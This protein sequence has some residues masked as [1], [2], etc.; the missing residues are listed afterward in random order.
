M[1]KHISASQIATWSRC[2]YLWQ[3]GRLTSGTRGPEG[4]PDDTWAQR[5]GHFVHAVEAMFKSCSV[6]QRTEG[7]WIAIP[8]YVGEEWMKN[9]IDP[10]VVKE[11]R[12]RAKPILNQLWDAFGI[13]E[14]HEPD[15]LEHKV[16]I[17]LNAEY[18][19]VAVF[20]DITFIEE[21]KTLIIGDYK[22]SQSPIDEE[23]KTLMTI[24]PYVYQWAA[25]QVWPDYKPV[26][27]Q[28]TLAHKGGAG[29]VVRDLWPE[30]VAEWDETLRRLPREME[31][32]AIYRA[33]SH[34][35]CRGC[36]LWRTDCSKHTLRGIGP[37]GASGGYFTA[38]GVG[39][40]EG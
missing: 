32:G 28:Y 37:V 34:N 5:I 2:R 40:N 12:R 18:D 25:K 30:D 7:F 24:Q 29:R 36:P 17:S 21:D 9:G 1:K 6:V 35:A 19:L 38:D 27:M 23:E 33:L 10:D 8:V 14:T 11:T 39:I 3:Q 26:A 15:L 16:E 4:G 20:D 31:E 22:T 13:D